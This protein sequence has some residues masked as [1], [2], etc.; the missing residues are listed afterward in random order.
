MLEMTQ[1]LDIPKRIHREFQLLVSDCNVALFFVMYRSL[2][3]QVMFKR[4]YRYKKTNKTQANQTELRIDCCDN[5]QRDYSLLMH[6]NIFR[7]KVARLQ[8]CKWVY[9]FA[10]LLLA[11]QIYKL[12]AALEFQDSF[13]VSYSILD[14]SAK[15]IA[16]R[17]TLLFFI[18]NISRVTG[19]LTKYPS[20]FP[21]F[22][23]TSQKK[24]PA[25]LDN[26][27]SRKCPYGSLPPRSCRQADR[28]Q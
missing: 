11:V 21:L 22:R 6:G 3:S 8:G 26:G 15:D 5:S 17:R 7:Y 4:P 9:G 25:L 1:T 16:L 28:I 10:I 23:F 12:K 20:C 19:L 13:S 27:R 18:R 2:S 24:Y 14:F